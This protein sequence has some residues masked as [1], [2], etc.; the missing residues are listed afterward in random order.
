M[1]IWAISQLASVTPVS[2]LAMTGILLVFRYF[3]LEVKRARESST[4]A[5]G[6][7]SGAETRAWELRTFCL[8]CSW[9]PLG[10]EGGLMWAR[11]GLAAAWESL[12]AL[13]EPSGRGLSGASG[14]ATSSLWAE[15]RIVHWV[16]DLRQMA[17]GST[18]SRTSWRW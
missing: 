13:G 9:M 14:R 1:S 15:P 3:R 11:W 4:L 7:R 16:S 12:R 2:S 17:W 10:W 5:M 8:T 6:S 18:L